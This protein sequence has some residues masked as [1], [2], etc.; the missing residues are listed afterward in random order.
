MLGMTHDEIRLT[1]ALLRALVFH[2]VDDFIGRRFTVERVGDFATSADLLPLVELEGDLTTS[3]RSMLGTLAKYDFVDL[4]Y[5]LR[6]G[7]AG[8]S[9]TRASALIG[10][11]GDDSIERA[12]ETPD[13]HGRRI[14][15][16]EELLEET[17]AGTYELT[18]F[19]DAVFEPGGHVAP[20]RTGL[21][22]RIRETQHLQHLPS[23]YLP[24]DFV[25]TD[26]FITNAP[27]LALLR[28]VYL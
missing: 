21:S 20:A 27:T 3:E 4:K 7:T 6:R 28:R 2:T 19:A 8:L 5:S 16:L 24:R 17:S 12:I 22:K 9:T 18:V 13:E 23:D 25:I 1:R 15:F 11:L 10:I 26:A 14:G